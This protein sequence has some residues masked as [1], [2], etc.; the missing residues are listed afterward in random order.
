MEN[1]E[2]KLDET[3]KST[4]KEEGEEKEI[5]IKEFVKG[6]SEEEEEEKKELANHF[7]ELQLGD[8]IKIYNP[9]NE[10]LDNNTFLINYIDETKIELINIENFDPVTLTINRDNILGDGYITKIELLVRRE[11][12]GY[13][14]QNGLVTGK[15]INI[16]FGGDV[17]TIITGEITNLE[18]DMIEIRTFPDDDIIYINFDYKGIPQELPIESIEIRDRPE[19]K[20]LLVEKEEV[21]EEKEE[22]G[23]LPELE[24]G[25]IPNLLQKP[26]VKERIE[27]SVPINDVRTQIREF[28]INA[29]QIKFGNEYLGPIVQLVDTSEQKQRYS[30]ESQ[31]TDLLDELLS[32]IPNIQRTPKVLNNI[33]T[34]IER[35]KQLRESFSEFDEYGNVKSAIVYEANFKPLLTYFKNFN[36]NLL[37]ILPVVKNV[38]KMYNILNVNP[39]GTQTYNSESTDTIELN[40]FGD[41]NA[42]DAIIRS[43][44]GNELT[45]E[46]EKYS[47]LYT[48]LNPYF[49]PFDYINAEDTD[50]IIYVKEVNE[51]ITTIINNLDQFYS[52]VMANNNTVTRRFVIQ[53]YNMGLTKLTASN[54]SGPKM[55]AKVVNMT[56]PDIMDINS[57]ITLPEPVLRYSRIN[58]PGTNILDR[59]NLNNV[60]FNFWQ[61]MKSKS[62][63]NDIFVDNINEDIEY[64]ENNF[65]NNIK[66]YILNLS[67]ENE[68]LVNKVDKT[69]IYINFIKTI[70]P[71]TRILFKLMKKYITGKLSVV[72]VVGFLEPFLVYSDNIT[73]MLYK[74]IIQ[75]IDEKISAHN[76]NFTGE[77]KHFLELKNCSA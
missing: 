56:N 59:A 30:I 11:F 8:V 37:W 65:A 48:N 7:F 61:L 29:D 25:E 22:T 41:L 60:Y 76:K 10:V 50:G 13:A 58:L 34:M 55:L 2:I 73:Y 52:T 62:S 14:R 38:K 23:E 33:H 3:E 5:I 67:V 36:K 44:R 20:R 75:F 12:P 74:D 70:I 40:M 16:Y 57:F 47:S 24:E 26:I 28:I 15:W 68:N 64:N 63:I 21:E 18:E 66:N 6:P 53:K 71:K 17:P 9:K 1:S 27:L 72:E 69:E 43:Y 49:T 46:N 19:R 39:L 35:F 54:F 31:T 45:D 42:M 77:F 51:N 4:N 32:T